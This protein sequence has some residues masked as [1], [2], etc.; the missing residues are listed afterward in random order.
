[1]KAHEALRVG[2][3]TRVSSDQQEQ[4]QTIGRQFELAE[5]ALD[6]NEEFQLVPKVAG[7]KA[8]NPYKAFF[9]DEAYNLEEWDDSSE[10]TE[11]FSR[12][13]RGE[14]N[15]IFVSEAN[16]VFRS[17]SR[18]LRGKILDFF[19]AYEVRLFDKTG[20]VHPGLAMDIQS[21]LGAEDKKATCQKLHEGKFYWT[22]KEGRPP[23]GR[24]P[25]G[26]EYDRFEKEWRVVPDEAKM[27]RWI[28]ALATGTV[29]PDLPLNF[30][31]AIEKNPRGFA[32]WEIAQLINQ[33]DFTVT[34]YYRRN[35]LRKL[36]QRNP[37]GKISESVVNTILKREQYATGTHFYKFKE[38]KTVGK[39]LV[40]RKPG[41]ALRRVKVELPKLIDPQVYE[42]IRA[43]RYGRSVKATRNLKY[44]YL[45]KDI[46]HCSECQTALYARVKDGSYKLKSGFRSF[47][48]PIAYYQCARKV[49]TDG[50]RC[51]SKNYHNAAVIE[52]I[53][54]EQTK[55]VILNPKMV[56]TLRASA[57]NDSG[58]KTE[59]QL[60]AEA[61]QIEAKLT[62]L[63]SEK[64][65]SVQLALRKLISEEDL[66]IQRERIETEMKSARRV[67][68]RVH[69]ARRYLEAR[70]NE[71]DE[72]NYAELAKEFDGRLEKL[73]FTDRQYLV[74]TIFKKIAVSAEGRVGFFPRGLC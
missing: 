70:V 12:I 10:L 51:S 24:T 4:E 55:Q 48:R 30:R 17:R 15:A 45:L 28:A 44:D 66:V 18:V 56:E 63:D 35:G 11:L 22:K 73:C 7:A 8:K 26:Y 32:A 16:R 9:V 57:L 59:E 21:I 20:E 6:R 65:R 50:T 62:E 1:M 49:R 72:V 54:W 25:L 42:M 40:L 64:R 3:Y 58:E 52:P 41:A 36:A 2:V 69:Q 19:E 27:I 34:N 67:L 13:E 71:M 29:E 53:V 31:D 46:L 5:E 68:A 14:I 33:T 23:S 61:A 38:T 37:L 39:N 74:R 43:S 47:Y 60:K